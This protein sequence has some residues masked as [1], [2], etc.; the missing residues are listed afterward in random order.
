MFLT[1][2]LEGVIYQFMPI[3]TMKELFDNFPQARVIL[4]AIG[5]GDFTTP[6]GFFQLEV[7]GLMAPAALV[8]AGIAVGGRALSGEESRRTMGLL[9]ANPLPRYRI[10]VEKS[11]AMVVC[12]LIVGVATFLGVAAGALLG[13]LEVSMINLAATCLLV[14]LLGTVF[15]ALALAIDAASGNGQAAVFGSIGFVLASYFASSFL[16]L[17]D[18]LASYARW[19]PYYYF[20][21]SDPLVNGM[22]WMHGGLLAGLTLVLVV[23]SVVLFQRRDLR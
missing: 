11:M 16:P 14:T 7:F 4:A 19:S 6:E 5:G 2:V 23:L 13:G 9:L 12:A 20:L 3:E 15:G 22:D 1:G 17:N 10:I 8:L 21:G 18:S